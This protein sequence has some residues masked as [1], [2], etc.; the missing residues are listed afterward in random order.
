MSKSL[1]YKIKNSKKLKKKVKFEDK[2][3]F[4]DCIKGNDIDT[5]RWML[6]RTSVNIDI[7]NTN[8]SGKFFDKGYLSYLV[9]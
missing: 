8:D 5:A 9:I 3:I 2:L 4:L 1:S 7:N 6:R